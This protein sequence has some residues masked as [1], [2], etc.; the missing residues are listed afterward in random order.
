MLAWKAL[1]AQIFP[2]DT[3]T[4]A[5]GSR[6]GSYTDFADGNAAKPQNRVAA[7][8]ARGRE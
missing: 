4:I 8:A 3:T 2:A 6:R 7:N 5:G 1:K